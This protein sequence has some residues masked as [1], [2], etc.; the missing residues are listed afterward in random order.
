ML[1]S[2][3]LAVTLQITK[4]CNLNCW[5][6]NPKH[7]FRNIGKDVIQIEHLHELFSDLKSM[8]I[9]YLGLMG[10]EPFIRKDIFDIIALGQ[11]YDLNIGI[12]TNGMLTT[13]EVLQKAWASGLRHIAFSVDGAKAGHE[14][15]RGEGTFEAV[16]DSV[17]RA[18]DLGYFVRI[19]SVIINSN[20]DSVIDMLEL[21]MDEVDMFKVSYFTPSNY[22]AMD[23]MVHPAAWNDY[24]RLIQDKFR[25]RKYSEI[26]IQQPFTLERT[27]GSCQL[28]APFIASD[29]MVYACC[30]LIG[31]Y[32]LGNITEERFERIWNAQW[33]IDREHNYCIGMSAKCMDDI[34]IPVEAFKDFGDYHYTCPL[35]CATNP[36]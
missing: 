4:Y 10:G 28:I 24:S 6:C 9:N 29:G 14:G 23:E 34:T 26:K 22:E 13:D 32:P 36:I 18:K 27:P 12:V 17:K 7:T 35:L 11:S 33:E 25:D 8:G 5:H 21:L 19:N 30:N 3:N 20:K 15:I 1:N 2:Q 31:E 16:V